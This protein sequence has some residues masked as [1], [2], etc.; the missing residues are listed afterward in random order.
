MTSRHSKRR[1]TSRLTACLAGSASVAWIRRPSRGPSWERTELRSRRRRKRRSGGH[2]RRRRNQYNGRF[3]SRTTSRMKR[4][5]APEKPRQPRWT[6]WTRKRQPRSRQTNRSGSH[7]YPSSPSLCGRTPTC[8]RCKRSCR[9][10]SRSSTGHHSH[11]PGAAD[12][13]PRHRNFT[14]TAASRRARR[15]YHAAFPTTTR[16]CVTAEW[17][18]GTRWR[19]RSRPP[20][21]PSGRAIGRCRRGS[22]RSLTHHATAT[23]RSGVSGDRR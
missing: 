3:R 16:P 22:P 9:T 4:C 20:A 17:V 12:R 21:P 14:E 23:M 10:R 15:T 11:R 13:R 6:R 5:L 8:H 19:S 2:G 18:S 1:P 7:R